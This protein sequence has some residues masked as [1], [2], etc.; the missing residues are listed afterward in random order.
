MSPD[1]LLQVV[2]P[3][4]QQPTSVRVR[5]SGNANAPSLADWGKPAD[6]KYE[7]EGKVC[8]LISPDQRRRVDGGCFELY[9]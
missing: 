5:V 1:D 9:N 4:P 2:A 6:T 7:L 3:G 8:I